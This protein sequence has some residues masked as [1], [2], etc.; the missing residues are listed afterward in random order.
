MKK[1]FAILLALS[2][3]LSIGAL[4]VGAEES[5]L[6]DRLIAQYTF[7][8]EDVKDSVSINHGIFYNNKAVTTPTFA[9]G[10]SGKALQLSTKGKGD[11]FWLSIPMDVFVGNEDTFTLSMWYMATGYNTIGEDSELFSFYNTS[12]ENFMFYSPAAAAFQDKAFNMKWSGLN[13]GYGYANIISAY[14]PDQWVHLVY[15]VE[16]VDGMS[17]ITAYINGAA[18]EVDQ[19]GDWDNSTMTA[20][21]YDNFTIGGK[22]PYKGGD[23]PMCLFYG[24]VD[25][26]CIYSGALTSEEAAAVYASYD[27]EATDAPVVVPPAATDPEETQPQQTQPQQTDPK[28]TE[29][30]DKPTEPGNSTEPAPNNTGLIIGIVIAVVA[31]AAIVIVVIKGK[32]K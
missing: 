22:N 8:D 7:D 1:L 25:E 27:Y 16:A 14:N 2:L 3:M 5:E 17:K 26:I 31:I 28:E 23:T 32:K 19:G 11:R 12:I 29:S 24:L 9:D 21:G 4:T 13:Q 6:S 20:M 18:V 10:V 30:Q 15:V